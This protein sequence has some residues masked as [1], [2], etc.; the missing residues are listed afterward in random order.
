MLRIQQYYHWINTVFEQ[1]RKIETSPKPPLIGVKEGF[2]HFDAK[3]TPEIK[4][5]IVGE[6]KE[7]LNHWLNH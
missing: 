1:R 2:T 3:I 6:L 5:T 4:M 7:K